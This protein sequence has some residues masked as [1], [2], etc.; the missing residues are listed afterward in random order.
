MYVFIIYSIN[1]G[2]HFLIYMHLGSNF[3]DCDHGLNIRKYGCESAPELDT[4]CQL[5]LLTDGS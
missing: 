5:P 4:H 3:L 2:T 1:S